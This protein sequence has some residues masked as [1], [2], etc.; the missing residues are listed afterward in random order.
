MDAI[1][2]KY[3]EWFESILAQD[4]PKE[5]VGF[6]VNLYDNDNSYEAELIGAATF[7]KDNEDWA[8]DDIFMSD[9]FIF[10]I[11]SFKG[12]WEANLALIVE[13]T[14]KYIESNSKGALKLNSAQGF[15][16]GFVD[17]NLTL[18]GKNA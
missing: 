5:I 1:Y 13:S 9:R 10:P 14:N 3:H 7:D 12:G 17:G 8:C 16:V 4:L 18:V 15:G 11:S 2:I 6:A